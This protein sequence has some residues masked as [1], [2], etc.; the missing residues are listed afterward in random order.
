MVNIEI[1]FRGRCISTH[2]WIYGYL[3][4]EDTINENGITKKVIKE[5]IS[6]YTGLVDKNNTKIFVGDILDI[7]QTVNGVST[8]VIFSCIGGFD[9]RYYSNHMSPHEYEYSIYELLEIGID[10][11]EKE[12]E[13]IGNI[14]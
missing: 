9:V 1:L 13:I 12:I 10:V 3:S 6:Q 14:Y 2:V 11:S 4:G 7:H 5:S 8:F